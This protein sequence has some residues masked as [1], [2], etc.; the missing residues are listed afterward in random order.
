M[1]P[2]PFPGC[3]YHEAGFSITKDGPTNN[4][5]V[6]VGGDDDSLTETQLPLLLEL[7]LSFFSF[8]AGLVQPL[9][10]CLKLIPQLCSFPVPSHIPKLGQE[11]ELNMSF[12]LRGA[13]V[14]MFT[15]KGFVAK[16]WQA[17]AYAA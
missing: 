3:T 2:L 6:A 11:E 8:A 7:L 10:Q 9:L 15:K 5:S 13:S 16:G 1:T 17:C 12:T 4:P 14:V